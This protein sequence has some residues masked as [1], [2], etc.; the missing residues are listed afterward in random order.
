[1]SSTLVTPS[2]P[3][4]PGA[5]RDAEWRFAREVMAGPG[6]QSGPALQW[7]LLR[8]CSIAPRQ[9]A[10]V[11]SAICVLSLLIAVFFFV[12]GAPF[13]LAFA[14]LELLGV[15]AAF[16][17]FARHAADHETLTLSGPTLRVQQCHGSRLA[18]TEFAAKDVRVEPAAAQGSLVQIS[19][20]GL[21]VQVGRFLRPDLRAELARELRRALRRP[22]G[23]AAPASTHLN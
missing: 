9:L 2:W 4:S 15:G 7:R 18:N 22:S 19:G 10:A 23:F 16:L 21:S 11:Y 8:N 13:V 14:G 17:L 20:R 6:D 1:M 5:P 3:L 12:Q